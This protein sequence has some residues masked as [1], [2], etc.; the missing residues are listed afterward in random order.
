MS[1]WTN[2]KPVVLRYNI[3]WVSGVKLWRFPAQ[4]WSNTA[5]SE[6]VFNEQERKKLS[7]R[8]PLSSDF[9][10][11]VKELAPNY[12]FPEVGRRYASELH[13]WPG[14]LQSLTPETQT[15]DVIWKHVLR[16]YDGNAYVTR[17]D[18]NIQVIKRY[19]KKLTYWQHSNTHL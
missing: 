17:P 12:S 18:I 1:P 16:T 14:K 4:M 15:F 7:E 9:R 8:L 10:N 2:R 3:V 19:K 6:D 11:Q 13:I 5:Q